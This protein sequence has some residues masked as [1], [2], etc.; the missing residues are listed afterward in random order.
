MSCL[1]YFSSQYILEQH[2]TIRLEINGLQAVKMPEPGTKVFL[3]NYHRQMQVPSVIYADFEAIT[4]K[5][6]SRLQYEWPTIL[7]WQISKAYWLRLWL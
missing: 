4:E 6:D 1:Q 5:I 7:Y 2:K 3:K